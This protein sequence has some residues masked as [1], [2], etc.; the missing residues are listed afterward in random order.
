MRR[1]IGVKETG[2]TAVMCMILWEHRYVFFVMDLHRFFHQRIRTFRCRQIPI[3][4]IKEV[5]GNG[6]VGA[7]E[8]LDLVG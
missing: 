6:H 1:G 4:H 2:I 8:N 7:E 5:T 3:R